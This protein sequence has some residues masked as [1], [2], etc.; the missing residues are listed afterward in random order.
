MQVYRSLAC[1]VRLADGFRK[2]KVQ[3][4]IA[5]LVVT[6]NEC[7]CIYTSVP[8]HEIQLPL[9]YG[10]AAIHN[11][12]RKWWNVCKPYTVGVDGLAVAISWLAKQVR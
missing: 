5:V 11:L 3:L 6:R 4:D 12:A 2:K 7:A 9:S 1:T 10:Q 8:S